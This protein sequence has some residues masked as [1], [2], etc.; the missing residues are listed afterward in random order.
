MLEERKREI[1]RA[2]VDEFTTSAVPVGS[3]ALA[4]RY[5]VRLS[6]ATIRNGL[7]DLADQGYLVQPHTSAGRVPTDRGYRYFVDFLMATEP[8]PPRIRSFIDSELRSVAPDIEALTE[9]VAMTVAA[10][11]DN[12]AVVSSP[13]GVM[14]RIK[15]VDLVSLEPHDLLLILVLEGNVLRQ[16]VVRVAGPAS[17]GELTRLAGRVNRRLGGRDRTAVEERLRAVA[18][19]LEAEVLRSV[20]AALA[21]YERGAE[22]LVV[23]D[24]VRNLLRHPEFSEAAR[25]RDVIEVLEETRRLASLLRELIGDAEL[26]VVIGSENTTSQ[27]HSCTVVLT[28]YGPTNRLRGVL[29]VVGPTRMRYGQIIARMRAVARAAGNRL[30]EITA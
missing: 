22:T 1:L 26:Q 13:T 2:V 25:V 3:H 24:G 16:Q 23:H 20:A 4:E 19:G 10:V 28:S 17:Q 8:I 27:L 15:H 6:P 30:A 12:A 14:A 11:T 21:Q 7:A 5:L 9:R 29:G 18:D